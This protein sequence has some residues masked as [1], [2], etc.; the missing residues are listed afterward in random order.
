MLYK[1][2]A[3]SSAAI[4]DPIGEA[5]FP[6]LL[7]GEAQTL[8]EAE[9]SMAAAAGRIRSCESREPMGRAH[10]GVRGGQAL[11]ALEILT[12]SQLGGG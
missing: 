2:M 5:I 11:V 3:N 10:H 6:L 4:P 9:E 8:F 12:V 1:R 7:R